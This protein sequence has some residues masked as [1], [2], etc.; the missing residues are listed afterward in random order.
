MTE[1]IK[2]DNAK[3]FDEFVS[4]SPKGH[5]MQSSAWGKVKN[6]WEWRGIICRDDSGRIKGVCAVLLRK[7]PMIPWS[8]MYSPRGPVCDLNDADTVKEL[9]LAAKEYGEKNRAYALTVDTDALIT[10]TDYINLLKSIG[11]KFKDNN[12]SNQRRC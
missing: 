3:E 1:I 8:M 9:M 6:N 2:T 7:M 11:F 10:D 5:M 4:A 12:E